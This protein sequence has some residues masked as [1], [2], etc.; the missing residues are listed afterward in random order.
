VPFEAVD[1]RHV[2]V[3]DPAHHQ[4]IEFDE[5]G[6]RA[7]IMP[8]TVTRARLVV[9]SNGILHGLDPITGSV[10]EVTEPVYPESG[11]FSMV[12]FTP[13]FAGVR[14]RASGLKR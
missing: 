3:S 4:L 1:G 12:S 5:R 14:R 11:W 6:H 9:Q 13:S 7:V 10:I 2:V 8:A